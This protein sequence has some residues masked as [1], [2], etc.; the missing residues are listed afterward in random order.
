[1][2]K[3]FVVRAKFVAEDK[4]S[5]EIQKV[6]GRF[7]KLTNTIKRSSLAQVAAF[8][9][10]VVA[11]RGLVRGI[12]SAIKKA[13]EQ[14]VAVNRLNAALSTLGPSA[15]SVSRAL[16]EQASA[17]QKLTTFGDEQIIQVQ[18]TLA[19]FVKEEEAIKGA[20]AATLDFS[21]TFGIDLNAAAQLVAKTLGSTTNA[22]SRYGIEVKGAVG[23]SERIETL[24]TNIAKVAGGRA[25]ADVNT[26]AG[27]MK[28]LGNALGDAQ[29]DLGGVIT[30]SSALVQVIR[31]LTG[32]VL[33][34]KSAISSTAAAFVSF[35]VVVARA[36]DLATRP[37]QDLARA[38]GFVAERIERFF[39]SV[40]VSEEALRA[41]AERTGRSVE[42]LRDE[43]ERLRQGTVGVIGVTKEETAALVENTA[44]NEQS[45]Q[46][47]EK[48]VATMTE[49]EQAVGAISDAIQ[50]GNKISGDNFIDEFV[51]S[52]ERAR[53][54]LR[55][56]GVTLQS[57]V[58]EKI[59]QY[60][61]DLEQIRIETDAGLISSHEYRDAQIAIGKEIA[62]LEDG[63]ASYAEQVRETSD[64][65]G[66]LTAA[67]REQEGQIIRNRSATESLSVSTR[68][69][70]SVQISANQAAI[71][72]ARV[73]EG[74][75][76]QLPGGGSRLIRAGGGGGAIDPGD[77][78][79]FASVSRPPTPAPNGKI[80]L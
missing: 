63:H 66:G 50:Q 14:E 44:T 72:Q 6:E 1:M 9:G 27:A 5:P 80:Q 78:G 77:A 3:Q 40:E 45:R 35:G 62:A 47:R 30:Q 55:D 13:N 17:L 36:I 65:T 54:T 29:E 4:A 34:N 42:E 70:T 18:T 79:A 48:S 41:T 51:A 39:G 8:G 68:T 60:R 28:Q 22:M 69:L 33:E 71:G 52:S 23:S 64:S 32:W 25:Q 20:T 74:G 58:S 15:D 38:F 16:Q 73:G 49:V 10:V 26:F 43:L 37:L 24:L 75:R 67:L 2:A 76:I 57:D 61:D 12:S 59:Q 46:Q 11:L 31:G 56:L 21:T 53:D 19:A 7:K